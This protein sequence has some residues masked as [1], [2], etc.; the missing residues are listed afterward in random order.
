MFISS[1]NTKIRFPGGGP[2]TS[3]VHFSTLLSIYL[4][5]SIEDV[6][7]EKFMLITILVSVSKLLTYAC[8]VAVFEVPVSP[9]KQTG[10]FTYNYFFKNVK[11]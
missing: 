11:T 9:I 5:T 7:E 8:V 2:Y 10:R 3:L 1:I 6:R 4:C